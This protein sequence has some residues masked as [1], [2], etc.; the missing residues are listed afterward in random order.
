[1]PRIAR[2]A[3]SSAASDRAGG[4]RSGRSSHKQ[5]GRAS[6]RA[7]VT[8]F[9]GDRPTRAED[10]PPEPDAKSRGS[11]ARGAT[12]LICLVSSITHK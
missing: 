9:T 4:G 10:L 3:R 2:F 11:G 6:A 5:A 1:M 12:P 7:G 8:A